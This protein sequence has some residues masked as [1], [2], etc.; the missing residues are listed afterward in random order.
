MSTDKRE[1]KVVTRM[2]RA[3]AVTWRQ[4]ADK[5]EPVVRAVQG[6]GLT[7][8]AFAVADFSV[9]GIVNA[10]SQAEVYEDFRAFMEQLVRG[11]HT[12]FGQI[13]TTLRKIADE[14]DRT[15]DTTKLDLDKFYHR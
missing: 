11:A 9:L 10:E 12:E 6:A 2:L 4:R 5:T 15:E 1:F 14:Y 3:E 13:D 7:E 8:H